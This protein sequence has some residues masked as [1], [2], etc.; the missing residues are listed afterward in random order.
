MPLTH[1]Q[2]FKVGFLKKCAEDGLTL[3]ETKQ[4]VKFAVRALKERGE[5]TAVW[6]LITGA[7]GLA[8]GGASRLGSAAL[9]AAPSLMS[10]L[11][12]LGIVAPIIAG[13]GTGYL[14]AKGTNP[15]GKGAVEDAKQDE[16][17]GE[18]ER[19]AEEARRRAR[20]KRLQAE[21]GRRVI[22]LTPG[23]R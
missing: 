3:E 4:R 10:T 23:D 14:A 21:T 9:S 15:D 8:V 18:Y 6:P 13:A 1:E 20:L 17:T 2:A 7:G 11:G 12:T 16:I 19:L 5:K 22:A